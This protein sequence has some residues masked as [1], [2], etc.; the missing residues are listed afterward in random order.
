MLGFRII[1]SSIDSLCMEL[2][3]DFS[4][5]LFCDL[6][7]ALQGVIAVHENFRLDNGHQSSFLAQCGIARQGLCVGRNA[8]SAGNAVANGNHGTPLGEA[9]AHAGVFSQPFAQ[10]IQT[11]GN[12]F[13]GKPRQILGAQVDL[14]SRNNPRFHEGRGKRSAIFRLLADRLVV[15]DGAADAF[16][17]S[18]SGHNHLP[19]SPPSLYG[20]RNPQLGKTLIT[21]WVTFIHRQ[22]ALVAHEKSL[23]CFFKLLYIHLSALRWFELLGEWSPASS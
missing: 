21:R 15:E 1:P 19:I 23:R 10:S 16:A 5:N 12:F 3:E 9:C 13:A 11:F 4:Q 18:G 6:E 14:D 20:L 2:A 17:Q 22:Q 8:A 7:A